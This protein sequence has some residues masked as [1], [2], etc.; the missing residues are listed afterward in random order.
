MHASVFA[1][2]GI[3]DEEASSETNTD[4]QSFALRQYFCSFNFFSPWSNAGQQ[5]IK[6][7]HLKV[8]S[9]RCSTCGIEGNNC[10]RKE[11][12]KTE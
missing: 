10:V 6:L 4:K 2:N 8:P 7:R 5:V 11:K 12:K 3:T 9:F 1:A